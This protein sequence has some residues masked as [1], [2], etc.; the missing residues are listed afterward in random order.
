MIRVQL[1][2]Q[3]GFKNWLPIL[4]GLGDI[5]QRLT[6]IKSYSPFW[7]V[8]NIY[9]KCTAFSSHSRYLVH[10]EIRASMAE[11]KVEIILQRTRTFSNSRSSSLGSFLALS[12]NQ[13]DRVPP[14]A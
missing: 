4:N 2:H 12:R 3:I 14:Q 5:C 1:F 13:I 6:D 9:Q 7:T 8:Q 10:W 11:A